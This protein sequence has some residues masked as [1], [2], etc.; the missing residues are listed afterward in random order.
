MIMGILFAVLFFSRCGR[1]P[2]A[3]KTA[4]LYMLSGI[5]ALMFAVVILGTF[6][7]KLGV[8]GYTVFSALVLGVPDV[9]MLVL[10]TLC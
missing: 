7:I 2:N 9:M 4:F 8:N 6:G 5:G 1:Y 3:V 10:F